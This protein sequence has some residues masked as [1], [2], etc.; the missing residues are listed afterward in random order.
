M[1]GIHFNTIEEA[2]QDLV[3]GKMVLV[4]DDEDRENEGDLICAAQFCTPDAINFMAAKARGLICVA[5]TEQRAHEL[6]LDV[7]VH[8]NTA[9]HG[10]RFTVSVDYLHG[11][12]T[13]ISAFDR[14]A[15]ARALADPETKPEDLARPGHVFPLIAVEEGVLRRAGHTEA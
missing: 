15:T 5:I 6:R 1:G 12:S 7:M 3:S 13:G 2:L 11:T 4:V 14:A 9:L 10:T 8:T